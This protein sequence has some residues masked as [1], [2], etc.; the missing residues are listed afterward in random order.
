MENLRMAAI[1][2]SAAFMKDTLNWTVNQ[3]RKKIQRIIN[4][5]APQVNTLLCDECHCPKVQWGLS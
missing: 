2:T 1:T 5:Q 3:Y 4:L